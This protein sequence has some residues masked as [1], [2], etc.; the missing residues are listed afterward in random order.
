[1]IIVK[2]QDKKIQIMIQVLI[3]NS[4]SKNLVKML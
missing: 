1:M 2:C 3:E 4:H